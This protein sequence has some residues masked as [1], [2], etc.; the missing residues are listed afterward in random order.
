MKDQTP[1]GGRIINNG[2]ISAHAPRPISAAY[3]ATKHAITGL[4]KSTAL[5]GRAY[6]ICL[7]PDRH[8]QR[9]HRDDRPHGRAA[10]CSPTAARCRSR[11]W[12]SRR[13]ANAVVYMASAA[14]RRQCAVHDGDGDQ[15]A[16]RRQRVKRRRPINGLSKSAVCCSHRVPRGLAAICSAFRGARPAPMAGGQCSSCNPRSGSSRCS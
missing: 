10:C 6:D 8:R 4:T 16:V 13:V 1:R 15:D 14:A 11:A 5:D 9:H 7:R 2:S 3:T 12:T